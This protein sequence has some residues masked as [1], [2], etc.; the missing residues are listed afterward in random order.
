MPPGEDNE[1]MEGHVKWLQRAV[2][3]RR[4]EDEKKVELLINRTLHMRRKTLFDGDTTMEIFFFIHFP[5]WRMSERSLRNSSVWMVMERVLK[6]SSVNSSQHMLRPFWNIPKWRNMGRA[7][8][9]LFWPS[10]QKTQI[11]P[12][13]CSIA[14]LCIMVHFKENPDL[15][16]GTVVPEPQQAPIFIK[17]TDDGDFLN[18][19][20]F[21]IYVDGIM[22]C[23]SVDFI[24][25]FI[26]YLASFYVFHISHPNGLKKSLYF[27]DRAILKL[28]D[29]PKFK[30]SKGLDKKVISFISSL[31]AKK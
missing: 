20:D 27:M 17:F 11:I 30:G 21:Y 29:S 7:Y 2:K 19:T 10:R 24:E 4:K 28:K 23:E 3:I 16:I 1:T 15:V 12:N 25:A 9:V 26:F 22:V 31:N 8:S 5:S 6:N 13:T 18:I 14:L